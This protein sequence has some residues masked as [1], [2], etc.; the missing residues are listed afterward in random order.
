VEQAWSSGPLSRHEIG[1]WPRHWRSN[2]SRHARGAI[3]WWIA[4]G[5]QEP[6]A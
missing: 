5:P 1:G 6:G 4:L 2:G 3:S